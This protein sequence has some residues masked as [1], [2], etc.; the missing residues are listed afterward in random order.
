M[1]NKILS[2]IITVLILILLVIVP[3]IIGKGGFNNVQYD[4]L[5]VTWAMGF[6]KGV[7]GIL[8]GLFLSFLIAL[9]YYYSTKLATLILRKLNG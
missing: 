2:I 9:V 6:F 4:N 3:I 1:L 7:L 8:A 5:F